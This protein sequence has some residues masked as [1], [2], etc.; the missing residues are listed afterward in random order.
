MQWKLTVHIILTKPI[1]NMQ[2]RFRWFNFDYHFLYTALV[3][4]IDTELNAQSFLHTTL[5][6]LQN[7][8]N[9]KAVKFN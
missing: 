8:Q 9:T 6:D 3:D 2:W 4:F 1:S 5:C 7:H